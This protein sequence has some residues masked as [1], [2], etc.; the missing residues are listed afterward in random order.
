[1]FSLLALAPAAVAQ[2]KSAPEI[3]FRNVRV[4]DVVKG[5]LG[6][7]T[8]VLIR[9]NKIAAIGSSPKASRDARVIDGNGRTLMPGLIDAHVHI[10]FGSL[11]LPQLYDPKTTPEKLGAAMT[12][13]AEL[14][15]LRGFTAVR[16]MGGPI[17][18][19][20]RAIDGGK[21][22]GPRIW[23]SGAVISQTSG[24]GD[25]RTPT[26]RS[27]RFFGKPSR[28]EEYGATFIADG[29][30]DV[31]T[32][33]R[34]N[35]R[36]G[37]SQIKL[38]AGGGTSSAYDP[39]DV[40]QY[41]LDEMKAAVEAAGD[42]NTYVAVHAYTPRAVRRAIE[43]G[44]K[45]IEHGQLLDEPTIEL[46]AQRG[47][48]LSAQNLIPDSPNMTP[49]RRKKRAGVLEGNARV[50]PMA[51]KHGVKLAWGTDLL[52]EPELNAQQNNLILALRQWFTP[53]EIL[54]MVTYDNA[55]LLALSGPRA[56]YEGK[57]GIVEEGALADL[58]LV[59]GDPL[60]NIDLIADPAEKFSV[61]MKD[62]VVYKSSGPTPRP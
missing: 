31:L 16:D 37:A 7:A 42:W 6:A 62:G 44:V 46:M 23:P 29:R 26:E 45:C 48:W 28:A 13:S 56:P 59:T 57:L 17:F 1:V 38:M 21:T 4:L 33:T 34:E 36:M 10:G 14:M 25:F 8:D 43:A 30:D 51:K 61:I 39:I 3:L 50:W 47:I 24:H 11:L 52:F 40:T 27:R 2:D 49:E 58:I 41:T 15:L 9:G 22:L 20:K 12:H 60:A 32:A 19:L 5:E 18:P 53:A 35:L 54:K 55:Q